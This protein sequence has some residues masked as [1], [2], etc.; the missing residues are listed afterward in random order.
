MTQSNTVAV[1]F[2]STFR[3]VRYCVADRHARLGRYMACNCWL[4]KSLSCHLDPKLNMKGVNRTLFLIILEYLSL[5]FL[6]LF[7]IDNVAAENKTKN[8]ECK[9]QSSG[10]DR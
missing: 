4:R 9:F 8:K 6:Y 3:R 2:V 5:I 1:F 10:V 7:K